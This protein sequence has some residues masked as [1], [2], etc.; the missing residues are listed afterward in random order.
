MEQ[1]TKQ[2]EEIMK[3][4]W[5]LGRCEVKEIVECMINPQP[6]YTTIASV[7]GKL[8]QKGYVSQ[9]REGKA[10]VY[11]LIVAETEY[12]RTF[13]SGFVRD[14][15]S[16]SFKDMVSFFVKDEKLTE[17]DLRDIIREIENNTD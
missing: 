9:Q 10:Y 1:L 7:V 14:Y 12:K 2:E 8:K 4:I 11:E 5:R 6:P 17:N 3:I 15:F 16:N 13:M